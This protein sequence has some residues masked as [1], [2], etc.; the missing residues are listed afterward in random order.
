MMNHQISRVAA[1][2]VAAFILS[3][4]SSCTGGEPSWNPAPVTDTEYCGAA[5]E[6]IGAVDGGLN[7]EEGKPLEM[8]PDACSGPVDDINCVS[9]KKFCEDTQAQG[10]WLNPRC[11][12]NLTV[13]SDIDKCQEV[14]R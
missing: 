4:T 13:C 5:C 3:Y 2:L 1:C 6:H 14:K 8:K 7:C 12:V 11:V 10:I 9:C